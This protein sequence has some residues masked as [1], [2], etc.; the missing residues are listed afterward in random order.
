MLQKQPNK[1]LIIKRK[2]LNYTKNK[3]KLQKHHQKINKEK[4]EIQNIKIK[5]QTTV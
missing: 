1:K 4:D 2:N 5:K 3:S